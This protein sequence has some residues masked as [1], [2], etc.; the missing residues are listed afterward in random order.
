[1]QSIVIK[2][3][4]GRTRVKLTQN[5]YSY[6]SSKLYQSGSFTLHGQVGVTNS[7]AFPSTDF[8]PWVSSDLIILDP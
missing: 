6:G 2:W 8:A 7:S 1:M 4:G 3:F 5:S